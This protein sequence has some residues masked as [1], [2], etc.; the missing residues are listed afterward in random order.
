MASAIRDVVAS[1]QMAGQ[2]TSFEGAAE[3]YRRIQQA[4]IAETPLQ[5]KMLTILMDSLKELQRIALS[6]KGIEDKTKPAVT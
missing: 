3:A 4:V 2:R 5:Q 6:N 1:V